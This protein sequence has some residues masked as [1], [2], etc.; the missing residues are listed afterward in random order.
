MSIYP[1][2]TGM[3]R[4]ACHNAIGDIL[5]NLNKGDVVVLEYTGKLATD[6]R[7]IDTTDEETA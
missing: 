5:A 7:V 2:S 6:G 1:K 3:A 4:C